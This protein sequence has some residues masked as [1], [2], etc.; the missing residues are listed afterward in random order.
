[1][2]EMKSQ[3]RRAGGDPA[4]T[5]ED[6][7]EPDRT[8]DDPTEACLRCLLGFALFP[9]ALGRLDDE[10]LLDGAGRDPDV[11]NLAVHQGLHPLQVREETPLGNG[12][13]VGTDTALLLGFTTPPDLAALDGALAGQ[14][15]NSCH[16]RSCSKRAQKVST[17]F[18]LA[19]T[20][21]RIYTTATPR[22]RFPAHATGPG[23]D[24]CPG[25]PLVGV[26]SAGG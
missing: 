15:T 3:L 23:P 9:G 1:M 16:T 4:R 10:A 11:A 21:S 12:R 2:G 14:F 18:D 5:D 6:E 26:C 13:D 24:S 25:R 17:S 22:L 7:T 20:I 8:E 19:S